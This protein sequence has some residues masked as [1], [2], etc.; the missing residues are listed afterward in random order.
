MNELKKIND[1][2]ITPNI[3]LDEA[4]IINDDLYKKFRLEMFENFNVL[5]KLL[6]L[7]M[8]QK[9]LIYEQDKSL[10]IKIVK[11]YEFL[12]KLFTQFKEAFVNIEQIQKMVIRKYSIYFRTNINVSH[13]AVRD[14]TYVLPKLDVFNRLEIYPIQYM[15]DLASAIDSVLEMV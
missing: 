7:K 8:N 11:Q 4:K 15:G 14:E 9:E 12:Q 2:P 13:L 1:A 6:F 5:C 10:D 3:D